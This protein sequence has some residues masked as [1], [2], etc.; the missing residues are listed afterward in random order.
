[1]KDPVDHIERPRLPWRSSAA[2]T[3][4]GLDA[5][6]VKTLSRGEFFQRL[7]DY[8]Q[9]RAAMITCMTCSN[10][11]GR[12]GTWDNDPRAAM[13]REIEWEGTG[14]WSRH[15]ERGERLKDELL[16]IAALI[17]AHREEF[18]AHLMATEQRREWL[19]KKAA[20]ESKPTLTR[21]RSL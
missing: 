12:W 5:S 7:K 6:K 21:P 17:D 20:M 10:T 19:R 14:R 16:A 18:E 15:S 3:E 8:G 9:Q 13:Q 4:C 11:A 1:M 2:V